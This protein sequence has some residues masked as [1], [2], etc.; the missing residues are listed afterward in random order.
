MY[1]NILIEIFKLQQ[2]CTNNSNLPIGRLFI[3]IAFQERD[4]C[5]LLVERREACV[6]LQ[7]LVQTRIFI[8][9]GH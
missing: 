8:H 3:I 5:S 6:E 2:I 1:Q 7:T 4:M 9:Q